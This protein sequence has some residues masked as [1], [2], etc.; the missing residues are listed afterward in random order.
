MITIVIQIMKIMQISFCQKA[1]PKR[2]NTRMRIAAVRFIINRA[3]ML[4]I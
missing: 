3:K 1:A 4:M 2:L